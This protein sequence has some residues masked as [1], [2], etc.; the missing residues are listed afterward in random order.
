MEERQEIRRE[1]RAWTTLNQELKAAET[2]DDVALGTKLAL[3]DESAKD[4]NRDAV[5]RKRGDYEA[6][7]NEWWIG[8]GNFG[9]SDG[10]GTD[11]FPAHA[12]IVA[13]RLGMVDALRLLL[14]AQWSYEG[15]WQTDSTVALEELNAE[16][17]KPSRVARAKVAGR[18][19][20]VALDADR[21][22]MYVE[23][24]NGIN[25]PEPGP[26]K[27]A[28]RKT[29]S[30]YFEQLPFASL[31]RAIENL[32]HELRSALGAWI[33]AERAEQDRFM[34]ERRIAEHVG[35][36]ALKPRMP[37]RTPMSGGVVLALAAIS[38]EM[39]AILY[40]P[41]WLN[42]TETAV[43]GFMAVR[44][45]GTRSA[46]EKRNTAIAAQLLQ[47]ATVTELAERFRVN[48]STISRIDEVRAARQLRAAAKR[49]V[50]H[51]ASDTG[52]AGLTKADVAAA[53]GISSRHVQNESLKP[54]DAN[55][56]TYLLG[57]VAQAISDAADNP[58][59]V[60]KDFI[61]MLVADLKP[62]E[63]D[64]LAIMIHEWLNPLCECGHRHQVQHVRAAA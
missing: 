5:R 22:K 38:R 29:H 56:G 8:F 15:P 23:H 11:Y 63:A 19:R 60:F 62:A 9:A 14:L 42:K 4:S 57:M 12:D 6:G 59:G 28:E 45:K 31:E 37:E 2:W 30:Y 27:A 50:A 61:L 1:V 43:G 48:P 35:I 10:A 36:G 33:R 46:F 20:D 58:A 53:L 49:A 54:F 21:I 17:V 40:I 3:I 13:P 52:S 34:T 64:Q 18:L 7:P 41:D 55:L 39:P 32:D 24:A 51:V 44:H 16:S 25:D 26:R 47:G